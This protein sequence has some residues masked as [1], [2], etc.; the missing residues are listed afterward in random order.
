MSILEGI[1][2]YYELFGC[3]GILL[4]AKARS[5]HKS[6]QVSISVPG[7][8][9]AVHLRLRT[10]DIS[11]FRQ[12]FITK[13]YECELCKP[14]QV[15]IDAGANIGLTS[16]FYAHKYPAARIIAIEPESSNFR[17]LKLNVAPYLNI[18]AV[19]AALWKS[20]GRV[21]LVDPGLGH[22]GFQIFGPAQLGTGSEE[23]RAIRAITVNDVMADFEL[24]HIDILKID[25]EGSEKEI[26][27][28]SGSWVD[29]IGMIVI[30]LH[31]H[32]RAGCTRSVYSAIRDFE[33][34]WRHGETIFFAKN[35]YVAGCAPQSPAGLQPGTSRRLRNKPVF[36][37]V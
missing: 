26:F 8:K 30:E 11:V 27:A 15:I 23:D 16:V 3:R 37:I 2:G 34:E 7:L 12:V 10:T 36:Q 14:P 19:Q 35:E 22:Y 4:G 32:L 18:T 1:T 24:P 25:V 31:E 33:I 6:V 9:H 5:L 21:Q 29:S 28:T 20:N 17:M 13:E